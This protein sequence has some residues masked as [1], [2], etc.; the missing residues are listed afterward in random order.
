MKDSRL[1]VVV[2]G[3]LVVAA[4]G[5]SGDSD[6]AGS[7]SAA[8]PAAPKASETKAPPPVQDPSKLGTITGRITFAGTPP[9]PRAIRM[10]AD[11]FCANAN[12]T[13]AT[14]KSVELGKDGG[15]RNVFVYVRSGIDGSAYESPSDPAVLDQVRCGYVPGV[16]G[17]QVGQ[18]LE[19]R[20][21]D[22]TLHNVHA[23]PKESKGFNIGMP[24]KGMTST[25]K[26]S[27]PEV[28]IRIKCDVHPWMETFVG[29]VDHPFYAVTHVSGA[30]SLAKLPPGDYEIEAV[31]P[32]LGS[33]SQ[34]VSVG[35][36]GKITV[37]FEFTG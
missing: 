22:K 17:L 27:A 3:A 30:Y 9:A 33:K 5:C 8:K 21:S 13:G 10:D 25:R 16:I 4:L 1:I 35:E 34:T 29:V 12:R 36:G 23:M 19:I 24:T 32:K 26:F 11:P 28:L 15:L 2:A 37:D 20:N 18:P 31:H 6:K 7:T 14:K